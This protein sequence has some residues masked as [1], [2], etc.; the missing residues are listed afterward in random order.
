[1]TILI[2]TKRCNSSCVQIQMHYYLPAIQV[3]L[4][5]WLSVALKTSSPNS[6]LCICLESVWNRHR[7]NSPRKLCWTVRFFGCVIFL[8]FKQMIKE[9]QL[10]DGYFKYNLN[11]PIKQGPCGW[12][13]FCVCCSDSIFS[14][15]LSSRNGM[16]SL[17]CN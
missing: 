2:L 13:F 4:C 16:A 1:M 5:V 15:S 7:K 10:I 6:M 8:C 11:C 14:M 9:Y 3:F 17:S 12:G